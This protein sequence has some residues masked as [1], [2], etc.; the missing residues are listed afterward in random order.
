MHSGRTKIQTILLAGLVVGLNSFGNLL[1]AWGMKALPQVG[2]NPLNYVSAIFSPIVACGVILLIFWLLTRMTL[3]SWA[4]LSFSVPMMAIG[5]TT[6]PLLGH[7]FLHEP[8]SPGRWI[9]T[10]LIFAGCGLVGTT[11]PKGE[12]EPA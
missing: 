3:L 8:V 9:G 4:D 11:S 2:V 1:L 6:A 5:Y 12:G 7:F 10:G